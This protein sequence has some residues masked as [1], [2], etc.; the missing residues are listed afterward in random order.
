M[1]G[2]SAASA[3]GRMAAG[4]GE[5]EDWRTA[6][7]RVRASLAQGVGD[8]Q[9]GIVYVSDSIAG[10]LPQIVA[11]LRADTGVEN[12]AGTVGTG[13][14][15]TGRA[16]FG[17]PAIAAAVLEFPGDT[18]RL[19][20]GV[21]EDAAEAGGALAA[22]AARQAGLTALLHAD[23]LNRRLG[24]IVADLSETLDAFTVGGITASDAPAGQVAGKVENGVV[25][26]LLIG[27][28][29]GALSGV[30]QGCV[31]IGPPRTV[32]RAHENLVLELDGR[33]AFDMLCQDLGLDSVARI[34]A[35]APWLHAARPVPGSSEED[36]LVRDIVGLDAQN[37]GIGLLALIDPGEQLFFVRRDAAAAEAD[38]RR[39]LRDM[40]AQLTGPASGGVYVSCVDRG[41]YMF[42]GDDRELEILREELGDLPLVGFF[43]DGEFSDGRIYGYTGVLTLFE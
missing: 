28:G 32:T 24:E 11:A 22:W 31:P 41:P 25:S 8:G 13:V 1:G 6:L 5:G 20:P 37:G 19:V 29:V 17:R 7:S 2:A 36:Y 40:S 34:R 33:P 9:A 43:A 35:T 3:A 42:G 39:M 4:F 21:R 16:A 12:W 18:L 27:G 10:R 23:P 30:S 38:L 26:G 15:G 14:C